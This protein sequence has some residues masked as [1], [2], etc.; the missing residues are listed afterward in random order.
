MWNFILGA[1]ITFNSCYSLLREDDTVINDFWIQLLYYFVLVLDSTTSKYSEEHVLK[2]MDHLQR[3]FLEKSNI[4][5][6]V[7][8]KGYIYIYISSFLK[9]LKWQ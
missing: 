6:E 8:L 3:V 1:A 9:W 4:F 2:S 5:N 7:I